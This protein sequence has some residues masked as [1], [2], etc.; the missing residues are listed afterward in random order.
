VS[1]GYLR[2]ICVLIIVFNYIIACMFMLYLKE[3]DPFH[4]GTLPFAMFNVLRIS[5][6]DTWDQML[7]ITMLGCDEVFNAL[8]FQ[9]ALA[10]F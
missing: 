6:L 2:W 4:F 1:F 5:T 10:D 3:N 8:P 9:D 7:G